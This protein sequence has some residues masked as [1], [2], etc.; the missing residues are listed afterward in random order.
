MTYRVC[1]LS[2][3]GSYDLAGLSSCV[4]LEDLSGT[5]DKEVFE[6]QL[7]RVLSRGVDLLILHPP[8]EAMLAPAMADL[9]EKGSG[10]ERIIF[11]TTY[12]SEVDDW[13]SGFGGRCV[14]LPEGLFG[15]IAVD[16]INA[17]AAQAESGSYPSLLDILLG[18]ITDRARSSERPESKA[19][20]E[21]SGMRN[22]AMGGTMTS[23]PEQKASDDPHNIRNR[24]GPGAVLRLA[25]NHYLPAS[26]EKLIGHLNDFLRDHRDL[27][28]VQPSNVPI[29]VIS[30]EPDRGV[31]PPLGRVL[32]IDDEHRRGWSTA[33]GALAF[34]GTEHVYDVSPAP[35]DASAASGFRI[36][37]LAGSTMQEEAVVGSAAE[38]AQNFPRGLFALAETGEGEKYAIDFLQ[39]KKTGRLLQEEPIPFDAILLDFRLRAE[40]RETPPDEVSGLRLARKIREMDPSV[41]IV[42][43]SASDKVWTLLGMR[44]EGTWDY[45]LKPG[46]NPEAHGM[47]EYGISEIK[48]FLLCLS[49]AAQF[50]WA[51]S[52]SMLS[53]WLRLI[54]RRLGKRDPE[55]NSISGDMNCQ[56]FFQD[57][58]EAFTKSSDIINEGPELWG[59]RQ[60]FMRKIE[61]TRFI[62]AM[63]QEGIKNHLSKT[64]L[65]GTICREDPLHYSACARLARSYR[66][67]LAHK[68]LNRPLPVLPPVSHLQL[69]IFSIASLISRDPEFPWPVLLTFDG[70]SPM[71]SCRDV[72]GLTS[73]F[74]DWV[75]RNADNENHFN[76]DKDELKQGRYIYENWYGREAGGD[77]LSRLLCV[78]ERLLKNSN[79][80]SWVDLAVHMLVSLHDR[81]Q[82][83]AQAGDSQ[84]QFVPL[85][86]LTRSLFFT[87]CSE[88]LD[89]V[90]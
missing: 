7:D 75:E 79:L 29:A 40:G 69:Q 65:S 45:F 26:A 56:R 84:E 13:K 8:S 16:V 15:S 24:E 10:S 55:L 20:E 66:N 32:L 54:D 61:L 70:L 33:F 89:G 71:F 1:V 6:K 4:Q 82:A 50:D 72:R 38:L 60:P 44:A 64:G 35:R 19:I 36:S 74:L 85:H 58:L 28:E 23:K 86:S 52:F 5:T 12:P 88:L 11:T 78:S 41:P 39:R 3:L 27:P 81:S 21:V 57:I 49:E 25:L 22:G 51:R 90:L 63:C 34:G 37:R 67:L 73:R 62:L 53:E 18:T 77:H 30:E 76:V 83:K 47:D 48:R 14:R 17:L 42:V 68:P 31:K 87:R 80:T 2:R 46:A 59:D 9:R 43:V